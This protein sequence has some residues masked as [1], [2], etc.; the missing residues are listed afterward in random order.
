MDGDAKSRK[1]A[2]PNSE[3]LVSDSSPL[4]IPTNNGCPWFQSGAKW[5]SSTVCPLN[6]LAAMQ[7]V[8][9]FLAQRKQD[10]RNCA[11]SGQ[12]KLEPKERCL[13]VLSFLGG[14]KIC[15]RKRRDTPKYDA[16]LTWPLLENQLSSMLNAFVCCFLLEKPISSMVF[17]PI[18]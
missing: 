5:I 14:P 4:Q 17:H 3:T 2:P 9:F 16:F 18:F 13:E 6:S 7:T 1:I 8:P 11:A 10:A 12:N 15:K